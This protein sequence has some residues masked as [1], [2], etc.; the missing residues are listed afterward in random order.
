M[1]EATPQP[2]N[3]PETNAAENGKVPGP[4]FS[5][6]GLRP[7]VLRALSDMGFSE[8][9]DVQARTLPILQE[10]RDIMVQSRTGSGKTAAF[11]IP[12]VDRLIDAADKNVQ[13]IV[14]LPTRELALQ[15]ASELARIATYSG[16]AVVPI[17]GGA[18]MGRQVEQLKA[19]APIVCGTPG[20]ILDHMR[21]GT[22]KLDRVRCAVLD[23]CDE[24]LSMGF[25]EDI[26]AILE[27]TPTTRQTMLFSATMPESIQ[28]LGR[29]FLKDPV[30]VKLS[31]DFVGAQEID[32][33]FYSVSGGARE[34]ALLRVLEFENPERAII[35]CNT[36][37]ETGRVAEHLRRAGLQAEAISSDLSQSDREKVMSL[38][39]ANALR[40]LV[41]T[42]VA[43]RGIDLE[44]LSHV[45]NF[46]FPESPEVY[47]HRT[48]RTG[49]AGR[50][51]TAISL[52][53]PTEVGGLY[54]VK[55]LY[56]I[57]PEER[58]L[59]SATE[60][61]SRR[62]GEQILALRAL[63][64]TEP[65]T[66]WRSLAR[67]V[68]VA[69]DGERLVAGLLAKSLED[70]LPKAPQRP[71]L[72][73]VTASSAEDSGE[74]SGTRH[75]GRGRFEGRGRGEG[76]GE[77]R[78]RF[79]GRGRRDEHREGGRGGRR[80]GFREGGADADRQG[81][82][83]GSREGRYPSSRGRSDTQDPAARDPQSAPSNAGSSESTS[84]AL[85]PAPVASAE[86]PPTFAKV[87]GSAP[88][89]A[90]K[91]R[92]PRGDSEFWDVWQED[93]S[94]SS[95]PPSRQEPSS[96]PAT[97]EPP[98]ARE[99]PAFAEAPVA[100]ERQRRERR[101]E[102]EIAVPEGQ[103]RVFLNLGRKDG[104]TV[105]EVVSLLGEAGVSVGPEAVDF[106]NTHSYIN[107]PADRTEGL[108]R[109]LSGRERA[110]RALLCEPARPR[111]R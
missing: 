59:P 35:F 111:R 81:A 57:K 55:L 53:G 60:V 92:A 24:M 46:S 8:A 12:M 89:A 48:G 20:R 51:G 58:S 33:V 10:G 6:L 4:A 27:A 15:V 76:R 70:G 95:G 98:V 14:L 9:M 100:R 26:E 7:D 11:G 36:R 32:H 61:T 45:F 17:Y 62:E 104:A 52:I 68:M 63:F 88:S 28:R 22:L 96:E 107:V 56:K 5:T 1:S 91:A 110:G 78:G 87:S 72:T 84:S 90:A 79:E 64:T 25:Q 50:H 80:D 23:E 77:G 16:I 18:P 106:M 67:R 31:A 40:F 65:S 99:R 38:M 75:E 44:N 30:D 66:A 85:A 43:A 94:A 39:R 71:A 2:T 42:D 83:D 47:I 21:R 69:L 13:A 101:P 105:E 49:R 19:G 3:L 103:S 102:R 34:D 93:S 86:A 82:R 74:P 29:R 54:Y 108:C 37:E 41:A 73:S 109:S 97:S